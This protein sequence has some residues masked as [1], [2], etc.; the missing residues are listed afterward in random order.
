MSTKLQMSPFIKMLF[1][2]ASVV[3]LIAGMGAYSAIL[4]PIILAMFLTVIVSPIFKWLVKKGMPAAVAL[5]IMIV[6]VTVLSVAF[7]FFLFASFKGLANSLSTYETGLNQ[8]LADLQAGLASMGVDIG[9][10]EL[11]DIIDPASLLQWI[12]GFLTT[13]GGL[14]G[15][16]LFVT[17]MIVFALLEV[18]SFKQKLTQGLGADNPVVERSTKFTRSLINYIL[19]RT[20]VNVFTGGAVTIMLWLMG[21][22]YALL[23]GIL[24]F[25]LSYVPYVGIFIATVPSV[26]LALAQYGVGAA[27]LVILGVTV[28]NVL[29]ENLVAPKIVGKGL[30]MSP[31]LV[32]VSFFFWSWLMGPLGMFLAMPVTVTVYFVLDS[33]EETRWVA[34]LMT[35]P[36]SEKPAKKADAPE[37]AG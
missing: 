10:I 31:L 9:S 1:V 26:L 23:W 14:A 29:A 25:F 27:I 5:L 18:T 33:F 24:T 12:G 7:L 34:L 17:L 22:D 30:S 21:I 19:A 6:A 37:P 32:F 15:T 8:A 36:G 2:G 20:L 35:M 16:A 4:N 13:L 3:I 28:I 11:S